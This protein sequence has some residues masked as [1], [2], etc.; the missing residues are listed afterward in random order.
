MLLDRLEIRVLDDHELAL[1]DLP[2][3]DD[4]VR[5]D[6]ALVGGA[7]ALLADRGLALPVEGSEADVRLL[8]LRRRR[9]SQANR[10]VDQAEADGSVPDG[11]HGA[12]LQ[13][14]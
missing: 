8:G 2:A 7:P 14:F 1:G 11:S 5:A 3:F 9:E 12:A 13:G 6:L 10:D 4:L